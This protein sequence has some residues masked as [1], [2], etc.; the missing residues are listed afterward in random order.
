M[1]KTLIALL[2][3]LCIGAVLWATETSVL[4]SW[5]ERRNQ[6]PLIKPA[7]ELVVTASFDADDVGNATQA[8]PLNG[9]LLKVV[10]VVPD[11]DSDPACEVE[12]L[13]N[14]DNK[15]FDSVDQAV[16]THTFNLYEP[17]T[18]TM[19]VVIGPAGVFGAGGGDVVVTLRGI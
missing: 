17:M 3:L 8:I 15:I 7:W 16:G 18:G 19:D 11:T 13:D 10:L 6:E 1:K 9:I 5:V 12:I 2:I 4:T 14:A